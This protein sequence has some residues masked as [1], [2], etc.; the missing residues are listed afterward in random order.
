MG[1]YFIRVS[2]ECFSFEL[3]AANKETILIG[4]PYASRSACL[5]G[6]ESVR[7]IA[8]AASLEDQTLKT[9]EAQANPKFE[10]YRDK[11]RYFYRLRARNG[12]VL[13]EGGG[14]TS[15]ELCMQGIESVRRNAAKSKVVELS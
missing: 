9:V 2:E 7:R 4:S 1:K 5:K 3:T 6:V 11:R 10:L 13:A 14:Y 15:K 8:S 12:K